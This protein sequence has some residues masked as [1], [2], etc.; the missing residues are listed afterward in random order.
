MLGVSDGGTNQPP[1]DQPPR[2]ARCRFTHV[3][4]GSISDVSRETWLIGERPV[5]IPYMTYDVYDGHGYLVATIDAD[6]PDDASI[7]IADLGLDP[8]TSHIEP[9]YEAYTDAAE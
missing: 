9:C 4:R 3:N 2:F 5:R 1:D 8:N 7:A 6:G